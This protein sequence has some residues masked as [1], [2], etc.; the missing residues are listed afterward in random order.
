M[1]FGKMSKKTKAASEQA[2]GSQ[3]PRVVPLVDNSVTKKEKEKKKVAAPVV[4]SVPGA[5]ATV[6]AAGSAGSA[7]SSPRGRLDTG[8]L[9]KDFDDTSTKIPSDSVAARA[10]G[11]AA[12]RRGRAPVDARSTFESQVLDLLRLQVDATRRLAEAVGHV[13]ELPTPVWPEKEPAG[14]D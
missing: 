12:V 5:T 8:R 9:A 14:G 1:C 2:D 11:A 6:T 13:A 7:G 3:P 10:V 4:V